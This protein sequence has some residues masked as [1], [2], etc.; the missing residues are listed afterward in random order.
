MAKKPDKPDT[1]PKR[2]GDYP[3]NRVF[4]SGTG[5]VTLPR[6][7]FGVVTGNG[8]PVPF[9][10]FLIFNTLNWKFLKILLVLIENCS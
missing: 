4:E 1:R 6:G 5:W 10:F 7:W 8:C 2:A 9:N 3:L